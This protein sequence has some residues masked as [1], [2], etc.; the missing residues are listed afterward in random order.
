MR[1][2]DFGDLNILIDTYGIDHVLKTIEEIKASQPQ[3]TDQEKIE[4]IAKE[5]NWDVNY[6]YSARRMFGK[7]CIGIVTDNL[8]KCT[9][10][11]FPSFIESG[12]DVDQMGKGYIV[13]FPR[14]QKA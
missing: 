1:A 9:S 4:R 11:L 14:V 7:T 3:E 12:F 13:Y 8:N 5:N 6:N 10:L 2:S